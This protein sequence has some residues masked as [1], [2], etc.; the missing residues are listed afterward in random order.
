MEK[1]N[2]AVQF[3]IKNEHGEISKVVTREVSF[4]EA[5]Q[6]RNHYNRL[7]KS[8]NYSTVKISK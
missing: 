7:S 8:P 3:T 2:Y 6:L 4:N 1:K 5:N